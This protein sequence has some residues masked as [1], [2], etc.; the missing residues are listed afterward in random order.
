MVAQLASAARVARYAAVLALHI[1][2]DLQHENQSDPK[3]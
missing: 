2:R 3:F 1:S